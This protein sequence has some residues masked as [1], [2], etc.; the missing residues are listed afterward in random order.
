MTISQLKFSER[1]QA[2][3]ETECLCFFQFL[4]FLSLRRFPSFLLSVSLS[5]FPSFLFLFLLSELSESDRRSHMINTMMR[6]LVQFQIR[7]H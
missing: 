5:V 6:Q 1:P 4:S 3:G 7:R 2:T